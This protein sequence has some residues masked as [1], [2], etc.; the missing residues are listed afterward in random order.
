MDIDIF[1]INDEVARREAE[2]PHLSGNAHVMAL[3]QLSWH[4]R[5]R[6]T[7]RAIILADRAKALLINS[8][9]SD[10]DQRHIV[11]RLYLV[12]GEAKWLFADLTAAKTLASNALGQFNDLQNKQGCSDAHWLLAWIAIDS[13]NLKES[14]GQ[15]ESCS[16]TALHV[17]DTLRAKIAESALSRWAVLRDPQAAKERWNARF[18]ADKDDLHPA[19]YAWREDFFGMLTHF[20]GDIGQSIAHTMRAHES[21]LATGQIRAAIISSTNISE[22]FD[23]LHDHQMALDW[24]RRALELARPTNWP[25][26]IGAC[27]MHMAENQRYIGNLDTAQGLLHEALEVLSPVANSRPYALSLQY[28]GSLALDR[29]DY[30]AALDAFLQLEEKAQNLQHNDFFIDA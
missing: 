20:T 7:Q 28:Q 22:D 13:G 29:Q 17:E 4:L 2:L 8:T 5:Q 16:S 23:R 25:R 27:L 26:S 21:S 18:K 11:A 19:L 15:F 12:Y 6:D 10:L 3:T 1:I 9:L 30:A 14:D 24:T